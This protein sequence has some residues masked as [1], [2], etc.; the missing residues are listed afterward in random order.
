MLKLIPKAALVTSD[1]FSRSRGS[2]CWV[3]IWIEFHFNDDYISS[4]SA[5]LK[6]WLKDNISIWI[7][8]EP[9][10]YYENFNMRI[11]GRLNE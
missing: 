8:Y 10:R 2:G 9:V 3:Q 11:F 7:I 6:L 4:S 1:S 5:S